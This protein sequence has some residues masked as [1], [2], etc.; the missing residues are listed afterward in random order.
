MAL[1]QDLDP[2][3]LIIVL[4]DSGAQIKVIGKTG[5]RVRVAIDSARPVKILRARDEPP[6]VPQ[7]TKP[8]FPIRGNP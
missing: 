7:I 4:P 5:R 8:K 6:A 1:Q 2:G 3:D